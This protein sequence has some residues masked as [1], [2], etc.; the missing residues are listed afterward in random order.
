[1]DSFDKAIERYERRTNGTL[2]PIKA[3]LVDMDGTLYD[4]MPW[5]ALAW[6]KMMGEAG[7]ETN[8]D[9]F[10][11]YEGMTGKAT[12][13]MLFKRAFGREV[14]DE[15]AARLYA[16]KSKHFK[17]NNQARVMPGA[18]KLISE[19]RGHGIT[20]VLVTGSGQASLLDRL[21]E[22]FEGE[23][24]PSL[25]VTAKDVKQG[26]P[27]PEPY[28]RG[29]ELAG[30]DAGNAIV[31]ENAPLGVLSGVNAGIFTVAVKTGPLEIESL[32]AAGAD[33]VF[34]SMPQCAEYVNKLL[35]AIKTHIH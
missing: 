18:K 11:A 23:F 20:P 17:E 4:S 32:Y 21:S 5:H 31:F 2:G 16:V 24:P 1:M 35:Y 30:V 22:E 15:E 25:R 26:K 34:E 6:H 8:P 14:S 9:E 12:I 19:L 29:L 27:A 28:L 3:A 10:F 33:I 7:V 13:N